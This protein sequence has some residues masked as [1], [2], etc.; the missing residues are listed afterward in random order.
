MDLFAPRSLRELAVAAACCRRCPLFANATQTVF[1]EGDP[2][3]PLMLVGEQPGDQ[4][5]RLGRAFVGPA[6][7]V[8][9]RALTAARIDRRKIYVTN[10]VKHFKNEPRGKMRLHKKP[11]AKEIDICRWW[12]EQE[13]SLVE[14]DVI[15]ALGATAARGIGLGAVTIGSLRGKILDLGQGRKGVVTIHPSALLR[16]QDEPTKQK[17]FAAFVDDLLLAAAELPAVKA[18]LK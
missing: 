8:L 5:D 10:A 16:L 18:E 4:E 2:D 13:I 14:P 9:D 1:G 3:A 7:R 17:E 6:G 11:N 12:L 15:V